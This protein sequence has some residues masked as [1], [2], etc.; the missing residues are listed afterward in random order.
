MSGRRSKRIAM[1]PALNMSRSLLT[2]FAAESRSSKANGRASAAANGQ[3]TT[4]PSPNQRTQRR[5]RD[6]EGRSRLMAKAKVVVH[7]AKDE[8]RYARR[9]SYVIYVTEKWKRR[10]TWSRGKHSGACCEEEEESG[11]GFETVNF[12]HLLRKVHLR[13]SREQSK[14]SPDKIESRCL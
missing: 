13:G 7:I 6:Q 4:E 5:V 9:Y 3:P 1:R 10:R 11:S 14:H 8:G 12:G 2:K